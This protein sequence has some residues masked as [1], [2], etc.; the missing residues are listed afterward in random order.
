MQLITD[1][2]WENEKT[3][4]QVLEGEVCGENGVEVT[5]VDGGGIYYNNETKNARGMA[6][7]KK[8]AQSRYIKKGQGG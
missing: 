6:V 8:T 7:I 5:V 4:M 2:F 1:I 3:N